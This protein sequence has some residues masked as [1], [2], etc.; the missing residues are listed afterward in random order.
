MILFTLPAHATDFLQPLDICFFG[1]LKSQFRDICKKSQLCNSSG[2]ITKRHNIPTLLKYVLEKGGFEALAETAFRKA[3]IFPFDPA[4]ILAVV[5]AN[6]NKQKRFLL[7]EK[8]CCVSLK[9]FQQ[10]NTCYVKQHIFRLTRKGK[11]ILHI[12]TYFCFKSIY[13]FKVER[14]A[15]KRTGIHFKNV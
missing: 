13:F 14:K 4:P 11:S 9:C 5:E 10:L 7:I 12:Y 3:G 6:E 15:S 2:Q 8:F 1:P